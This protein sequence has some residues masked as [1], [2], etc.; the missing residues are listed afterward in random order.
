MIGM[1]NTLVN[2]QYAVAHPSTA[3]LMYPSGPSCQMISMKSSAGPPPFTTVPFDETVHEYVAQPA[4][5]T[6][7]RWRVPGHTL[8]TQSN[9]GAGAG[10]TE[11]TTEASSRQLQIPSAASVT[12]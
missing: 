6:V 9:S 8:L 12:V 1:R 3:R 5:E 7:Y 10:R 4:G 2:E 11:T